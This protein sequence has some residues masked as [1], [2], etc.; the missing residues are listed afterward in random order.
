MGCK[1][2]QYFKE[3]K[4]IAIKIITIFKSELQL[5]KKSP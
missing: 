2:N 5:L 3:R 4:L 1:G